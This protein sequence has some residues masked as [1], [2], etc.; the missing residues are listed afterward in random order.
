MFQ[1]PDI[2]I[3]DAALNSWK[4]GQLAE[5]DVLLTAA[6]HT[7]SRSPSHVLASRAL[8]RAR[9]RQWDAAIV[10]ANKVLSPLISHALTLTLL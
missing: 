3:D 5:T 7:A 8:V 2:M 4:H 9:L 10:D 6:F 1:Q